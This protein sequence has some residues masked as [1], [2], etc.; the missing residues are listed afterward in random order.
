MRYIEV[1]TPELIEAVKTKYDLVDESVELK[2]QMDEIKDKALN[3]NL[4]MGETKDLINELMKKEVE[5]LDLDEF[6]EE[7]STEMKDGVVRFAVIDK[8]ANAKNALRRDK[9]N[10]A[11]LER[12]EYTEAEL[13]DQKQ[14]EFL[15]HVQ[16]LQSRGLK[17]KKLNDLLDNLI[18][19]IK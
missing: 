3:V 1:K 19:V 11:R 17:P 12:G 15:G 5:A 14:K 6:E 10:R 2:K 13:L 16:E 7:G 9:E 18:E 8:L 4:R